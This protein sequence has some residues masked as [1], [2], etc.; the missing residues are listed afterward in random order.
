MTNIP[1]PRTPMTETGTLT[2]GWQDEA[3]D[4]HKDFE[5]RL[6]TMADV[7]DAMAEAGEGANQ[8]RITRYVWARTITRLGTLPQDVITPELLGA[9][10]DTEFG[11]LNAAEERLRKKLMAA[12]AVAAS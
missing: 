2:I 3:G 7:E 1:M 10:P 8:A 9:L 6:P 11:Q 12:S 4:W 5:M